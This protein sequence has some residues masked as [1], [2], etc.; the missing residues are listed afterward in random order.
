MTANGEHSGASILSIIITSW[1]TR[2]L[3]RNLLHSIE[4]HR[5]SCP[6]EV[7]VVDNGSTDDSP[8]MVSN[9]FPGVILERNEKN[10]GYARASGDFILLPGSDTMLVDD[11]IDRMMEY[12]R[13]HA[14]TGAVSCR[15]LNPDRTLQGSCR[16]FP[17]LIDGIATDLSPHHM[18]PRYNMKGLDSYKTQEVEQ[19]AA[20]GLML[21]RTAV[22]AVGFSYERFTIPYYGDDW[23]MRIRR[24]GWKTVSLA[25]GEVIHHGSQSTRRAS[26]ELRLEMYRNILL[27]YETH[28][29]PLSGWILRPSLPSGWQWQRGVSMVFG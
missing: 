11:V 16:H 27:Y 15:L 12:M 5:P 2:E 21:R 22:D 28:V 29:H 14:D 13:G 4:V 23:C 7:I 6:Y 25:N 24:G 26:P 1:G 3:L 18:A 19:P 17:T 20:T 8:T 10:L 9:E